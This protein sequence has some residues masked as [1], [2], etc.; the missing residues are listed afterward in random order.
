V[1]V[2]Y[3]LT[4]KAGAFS[5]QQY[6]D[7]GWTEEALIADDY[8]A[9]KPTP[10]PVAPPPPPIPAPS[11]AAAPTATN[12]PTAP[13]H[14]G[15]L[16]LDKDGRPWD[17]DIDSGTPK[18]NADGR[19]ARRKNLTDDFYNQRKA[20]LISMARGVVAPGHT[21]V[22]PT[23]PAPTAPAQVPAKPSAGLPPGAQLIR[24]FNDGMKANPTTVN[25][26]TFLAAVKAVG[27]EAIKD[28][29]NPNNVG[30]IPAIR[31]QLF[32]A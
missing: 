7:Q 19:W 25:Q 18:K 23:P 31:L 9:P 32:G 27:L 8:L 21:A 15:G 4:E 17:A 14:S 11:I 22:T 2:E 29:S 30:L 24:D 12:V 5:L 10:V 20:L 13:T 26:V 28:V 6:L 16:E 3:V 1:K